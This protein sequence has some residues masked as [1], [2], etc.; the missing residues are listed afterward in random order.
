MATIRDVAA[1]T[2]V[3]IASVSRILN[4]DPT[5]KAKDSTRQRVF[6]AAKQLNYTASSSAKGRKQPHEQR[7]GCIHRLTAEKQVDSY[8]A[9]ILHGI[10]SYLER[11]GYTLDFIQSQFDI[12]DK[13]NLENLFKTPC[14]GLII[15]DTPSA[16]TMG[17]YPLQGQTRGGR[18]HAESRYRQRTLQPIR[19]R[20]P[21][22]CSIFWTTGTEKSPIS[23]P[24]CPRRTI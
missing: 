11:Q 21:R 12:A 14:K 18:R 24:N 9:A 1:A 23:A 7:I 17:V 15:M 5:Y 2:G 6:E 22:P 10:Q 8:Y 19:G 13:Q 3:S 4:Q 16:D 20:L